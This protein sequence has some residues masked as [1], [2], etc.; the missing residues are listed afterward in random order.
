MNE[1]LSVSE[2]RLTS[3]ITNYG[4]LKMIA[5]QAS[6]CSMK[7]PE[8]FLALAAFLVANTIIPF[9]ATLTSFLACKSQHLYLEKDST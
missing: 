4:F 3:G 7:H 6:K 1:F 5:Q 8:Q 2:M 9:Y